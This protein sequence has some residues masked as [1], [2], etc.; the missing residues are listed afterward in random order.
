MRI[1]VSAGAVSIIVL[2][3]SP[4]STGFHRLAIIETGR[5]WEKTSVIKNCKNPADAEV[6][7]KRFAESPGCTGPESKNEIINVPDRAEQL[8]CPTTEQ[9]TVAGSL[10]DGTPLKLSG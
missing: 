3:A 2:L 4:M 5:I 9:M 8:Y 6:Y 1:R 10:T 7:R